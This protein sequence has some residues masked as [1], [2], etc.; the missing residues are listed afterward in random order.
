MRPKSLTPW[1]K[2]TKK[3]KTGQEKKTSYKQ[4]KIK[5]TNMTKEL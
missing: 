1:E 2:P 3:S 4:D 5:A